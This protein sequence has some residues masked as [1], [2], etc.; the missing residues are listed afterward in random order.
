[1]SATA[2]LGARLVD[3]ASGRDEVGGLLAIDGRIAGIGAQLDIPDEAERV[4]CG[5]HV[6]APGIV[7]MRSFAVDAPSALAG[8]IT[9]VVLMPDQAPPIDSAAMIEYVAKPEPA[10]ACPRVRPMGAATRNLDGT[11]M[12]ELGLMSEAGAVGFTD[13]RK[14]IADPLVM[15][16]L[17]EYARELGRP[18]MQHAEEPALAADGAMNEGEIATRLG[19]P[20]IP[21]TAEALIIERDLHLARLTGGRVHVA[22]VSASLSLEVLRR[23]KA[24]G[25]PV[26]CG[27]SPQHFV[28]NETAVG[29]YRTFAKVSPPLRSEAD[30][31]A[32]AAA[33]AEGVIDV[34]CSSHEPRDQDAKRLPFS[35][36]APGIVGYETLLP[37]AL[38]L[39]RD[40]AMALADVLALLTDRPARLLGLEV[41]RLEPGLPADLMLFDP[42]RPWRVEP[43]MLKSETQNTP[44]AEMQVQGRVLRTV[45]AG[46]T[47]YAQSDGAS[48]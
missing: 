22:Q 29:D 3:P 7:D 32:L 16:R 17:L 41:G 30:R 20:G 27:A 10:G 2:F 35:E 48:S 45:I 28:L 4:D 21:A 26:T 34:L 19:L 23:A 24:S 13:G 44:F 39:Y 18:I 43:E 8:G 47:V 9:T 31:A 33:I 14:T 46:R 11:G 15:R 12:A 37:L 36:A 6:L 38:S 42:D 25:L 1:M 40:E 5:G